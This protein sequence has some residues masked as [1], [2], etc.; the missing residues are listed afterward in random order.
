LTGFIEY[1]VLGLR[2]GLN[3]VLDIVQ[4]NALTTSWQNYIY[5]KLDSNV[6]KGKTRAV[7][8]RRRTLALAFPV[9]RWISL[10]DLIKKK[11]SLQR[12]MWGDPTQCRCVMLLNL[13]ISVSLFAK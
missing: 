12:F 6:A 3:E 9:D 2:D 11:G 1:A 7:V 10:D 4:K 5:E 13:K 8:K